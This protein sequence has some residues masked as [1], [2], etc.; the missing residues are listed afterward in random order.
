MR[1]C[2]RIRSVGEVSLFCNT[3]SLIFLPCEV[4]PRMIFGYLDLAWGLC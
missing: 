1:R 3:Y 2:G 4:K